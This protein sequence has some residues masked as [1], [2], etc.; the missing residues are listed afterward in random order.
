MQAAS[1]IMIAMGA[2][3]QIGGVV[4][5]VLAEPM[6]LLLLVGA[7]IVGGTLEVTGVLSWL[8]QHQ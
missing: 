1:I 2:I 3:V 7:L 8:H 5:A 4:T 6:N